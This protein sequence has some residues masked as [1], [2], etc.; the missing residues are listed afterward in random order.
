MATDKLNRFWLLG[1][2]L[3]IIIIVAGSIVIGVRRGNGEVLT[4]SPP[5]T[6]L[7]TGEIYIDGAITNPGVYP[8][9]SSDDIN[10]VIQASG[11]AKGNA[12]LSQSTFIFFNSEKAPNRK[13]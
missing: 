10:S 3:L 8:L 13:K 11:G 9:K 1:I 5:Q 6:P 4:I 7:F 12:D 2:F